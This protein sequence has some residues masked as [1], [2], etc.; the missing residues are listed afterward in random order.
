METTVAETTMAPG[1]ADLTRG[2][3]IE[4]LADGGMLTGHV[5]S[6]AVLLARIGDEFF[7]VG[8]TCTHYSAPLAEGLL[9]GDTVRCPWHH[10]CF[11]LRTGAAS[12]PPALNDL[13]R[14]RVEVLDGRV[15]VR[16]K[17]PPA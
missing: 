4:S 13:P 7:A 17:L 2:V 11:N 12:R 6:E 10:A 1:G 9:V 8:A 3:G 14:W 15:F 16:D 5:G